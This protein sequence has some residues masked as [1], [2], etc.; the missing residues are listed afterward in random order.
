MIDLLVILICVDTDDNC[1]IMYTLLCILG[2]PRW[3]QCEGVEY[4]LAETE[5]WSRITGTDPV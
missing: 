4:R 5:Y 3:S 1:T 2:I